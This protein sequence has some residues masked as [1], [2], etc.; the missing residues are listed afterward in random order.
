MYN[1]GFNNDLSGRVNDLNSTYYVDRDYSRNV[2]EVNNSYDEI[3]NILNYY[4]Q[5]ESYIRDLISKFS[6]NNLGIENQIMDL[7][8]NVKNLLKN[9]DV[10]LMKSCMSSIYQGKENVLRF[11][12]DQSQNIDENTREIMNVIID[13][14]STHLN[15]L[16]R[17]VNSL[18]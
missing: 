9:R 14:Y 7:F 3:F 6:T 16:N 2:T 4:D 8:N 15:Y 13:E 18:E 12:N 11:I 17:A 10:N 5:R 1:D